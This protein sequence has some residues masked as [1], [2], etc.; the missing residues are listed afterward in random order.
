LGANSNIYK[1]QSCEYVRGIGVMQV[2][3]NVKLLYWTW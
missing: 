1:N 2:V 3:K